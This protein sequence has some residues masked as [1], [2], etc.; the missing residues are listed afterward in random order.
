MTF[1]WS[2]KVLE[3]DSGNQVHSVV[4]VLRTVAVGSRGKTRENATFPFSL[5]IDKEMTL[6]LEAG[7]V[8]EII[9]MEMHSIEI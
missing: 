8:L 4:V 1:S 2:P 9:E 7:M 3:V 6:V 5:G